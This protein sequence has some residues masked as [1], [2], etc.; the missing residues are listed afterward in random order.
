MGFIRTNRKLLSLS[1]VVM[2]ASLSGSGLAA[3]TGVYFEQE[4]LAQNFLFWLILA[5]V[6]AFFMAAGFLS[7][8]VAALFVGYFL[9]WP[10]LYFIVPVYLLASLIGNL[11]T[12]YMDRGRLANSLRE[13]PGASQILAGVQKNAMAM[14][15]LAR[16]SPSLPFALMNILLTGTGVSIRS[17]L[18]GGLLGMLPRT[19]LA[20][21]IAGFA[22]ELRLLL[23]QENSV[24]WEG[25]LILFLFVFSFAGMIVILRRSLKAALSSG[26]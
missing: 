22:Q 8:T 2:L 19:V 7:S 18:L 14:V 10:A 12:K 3:W 20:V 16:L 23:Q 5:P 17:Y 21:Y 9:G 11:F 1:L 4:M 24:S 26:R 15:F 13:S 6:C 25:Y